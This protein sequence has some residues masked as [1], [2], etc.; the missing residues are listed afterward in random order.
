[1]CG[2]WSER[3]LEAP[4]QIDRNRRGP[5]KGE[6]R[7][8]IASREHLTVLSVTDDRCHFAVHGYVSG[9]GSSLGVPAIDLEG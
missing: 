7:E 4:G 1:M 6:G 3:C 9:K 8:E 2:G 5:G